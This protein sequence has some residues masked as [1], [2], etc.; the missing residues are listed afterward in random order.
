VQCDESRL[1]DANDA[2]AFMIMSIIEEKNFA[3]Y[4]KFCLDRKIEV[5]VRKLKL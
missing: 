3:T 2:R 1:G 4:K 5:L